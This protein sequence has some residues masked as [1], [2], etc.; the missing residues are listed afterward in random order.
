MTALSTAFLT[1]AT[2]TAADAGLDFSAQA[3]KPQAFCHTGGGVVSWIDIEGHAHD[4]TCAAG[5]PYPVP[6]AIESITGCTGSGNLQF[7]PAASALPPPTT[8]TTL[9]T[10][11]L[12]GIT[13]LSTA[14]DDAADP[15]AVGDND[16][17][18]PPAPSA[19]TKMLYDTGTAYSATGA[20]TAGQIPVI[21]AGA[22]A[23]AMVSISGDATMLS[24][25]ALT[26]AKVNGTSVPATPAIGTSL[27]AT[28]TT[29]AVYTAQVGL[30]RSARN[31][32][33]SDVANLAAYTV[34]AAAL[35]DNVS[36]GNVE[37]DRVLLVAQSTAAQNGLYVCGAVGGG[38][39]ALTRAADM[40]A[41]LVGAQGLEVM[42]GAGTRFTNTIWFA[43][44]VGG[45]TVGTND[46]A[47]YPRKYTQ[48]TTAMSGTPGV[49]AL[50]AEWILS[51][52]LSAVT[53]VAKAP[54]TQ[55][56]LSVGT[57]TAGAGNG[58]VTVTSSANE[59]STL[60]VTIEN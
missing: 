21:N 27:F 53:P 29:T 17:R 19:A 59:T 18:M 14:A 10:A 12:A 34:A 11:A 49:K 8:G 16:T 39:C 43:S 56:F 28:S 51:A 31:V 57:L 40:P 48:V 52:T 23:P 45:F 58:A 3:D 5:V 13:K 38:T 54:G 35:N 47:F 7:F 24:T 20:G 4:L 37:G 46:P 42:V 55:G 44:R 25:G 9:A 2:T 60:Q 33:L 50:T 15:I 32:V 41:T 6:Y 30:A 1:E 36:G 22:T 26:V